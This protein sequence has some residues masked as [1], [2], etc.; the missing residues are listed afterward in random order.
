MGKF[1]ITKRPNGSYHFD[2][3]ARNGKVILSSQSY[4]TKS[5]CE[6]G[7]ESVLI[8]S[9]HESSFDR[10][11]TGTGKCFFKLIANNGKIIG[12]SELYANLTSMEK[13]IAAVK[14]NAPRANIDDLS[15]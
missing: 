15:E 10:H 14:A 2:L 13:G 9:L 1:E 5:A 4:T 3:K 12:T 8:N 7:L 11:E 6:K